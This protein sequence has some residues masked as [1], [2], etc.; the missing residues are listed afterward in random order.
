MLGTGLENQITQLFHRPRLIAVKGSDS[1]FVFIWT[2]DL[3]RVLVRAAGEGPAGIYN[4]C[5][6]G[7]LSVHE[8]RPGARQA[9][10][11]LP[12]WRSRQR[13]ALPGRSGSRATGRN[14]SG[15]CNTVRCS[16]TPRSKTV[17]GYRPELSSAQTFELWRKAAGL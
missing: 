14:R 3:A 6:D 17:F 8:L 12:A 9:V 11:A 4:V 16:T 1:P 7:A 10:M 13:S 2:R 15:S 5:G